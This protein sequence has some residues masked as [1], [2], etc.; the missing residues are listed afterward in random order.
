MNFFSKAAG[1][2]GMILALVPGR[3]LAE[4]KPT[5]DAS[6]AG[7]LSVFVSDPGFGKD[8]YF[9]KSSRIPHVKTNESVELP[10]PPPPSVPDEIVLK[11]INLLKDRSYCILNNRTVT[12]GEDFDLKI[13]GKVYKVRCVEI[14]DKSVVI[15]VNGISKEL[16]L[17]NGL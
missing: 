16:H 2:T 8:P 15:S 6:I 14:K 11:G 5:S 12:R 10:S 1:V 4:A 17:R 9:P 3:A 13:K 7:P